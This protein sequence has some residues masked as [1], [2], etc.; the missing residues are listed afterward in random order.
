MAEMISVASLLNP[1]AQ[2]ARSLPTP[3]S[4][5][6][7]SEFDSASPPPSSKKPKMTKDAAVFVEGKVRGPI[8]YA[9]W[10]EYD[11]ETLEELQRFRIFPLGHIARYHRHIPYNSEKKAFW[12]KTGR[13][14]FEGK[15]RMLDGDNS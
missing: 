8:R 5:A 15:T 7:P 13:G 4:T 11:P 6:T 3:K 10:E 2:E 9:P 14:A 1:A 12:E